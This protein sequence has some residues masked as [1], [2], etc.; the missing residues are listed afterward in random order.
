V[1]PSQIPGWSA[2]Q[3]VGTVRGID[4]ILHLSIPVR[5]LDEASR[6]Y[7]DVLGCGIGRANADFVDIWF[8]GMQVTLQNRPDRV[9]GLDRTGVHHFGVTLDRPAF[10][11]AVALVDE[12]GIPWLVEVATDAPGTELEQTKAKLA[13][14]SGNVIELKT[15]PDMRAALSPP[16]SGSRG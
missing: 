1:H 12:H 5:D 2:D 3:G 9:T 13:D 6:F 11:A 7:A 14:P 4:P 16:G 8:F 10:D 15:Y